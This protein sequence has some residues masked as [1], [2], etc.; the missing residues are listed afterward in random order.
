MKKQKLSSGEI[1]RICNINK[2]TLFYYDQIDLF[3]PAIIE[4]NGY[5]YYTNDQIDILSKIKALQ[6]VGLTLLEIKEQLSVEDISK[7]IIT[8][9]QQ[10]QKIQERIGELEKVKDALSQQIH[11]LE[12]YNKI[13]NNQVFLRDYEEEYLYVN[14]KA[15]REEVMTNFLIDGYH[16]GIMLN[17]SENSSEKIEICKFKIVDNIKIA[18]YK[19]EK[20]KFVGVYFITEENNIIQNTLK[21]LAI[22][23]NSGHCTSGLVYLKDI[24]NDFVNFRNGNIP[25]Q[26]TMKL[27][28]D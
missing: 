14:E 9:H 10:R 12:H 8:L 4:T 5:R 7:G 6:S 15:S 21:A 22:I 28:T 25:F 2:K 11:E 23:K 19:K 24:A 20:G 1:A 26:I 27:D 18:N 3:K 13:G 17:V 16:F